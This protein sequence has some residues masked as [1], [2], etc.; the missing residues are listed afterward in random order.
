MKKYK[1]LIG[2]ESREAVDRYISSFE[3]DRALA[4]YIA[5]VLIAH[6]KQLARLG[7][8]KKDTAKTLVRELTDIMNSDGE[9]V[10]EWARTTGELYED[11]FEAIELYLYNVV[12]SDA[13]RIA[14]GRSRNDHI[15]AVLRL[16]IRDR[17]LEIAT[18]ILDLRRVLLDKASMYSGTLFPFFTHAQIA[19]CGSASI[20]FLT[21]EQAFADVFS[22][23]MLG[24]H[25]LNQ[26]PLGSGAAAGTFVEFD[27][28]SASREL[29]LSSD[30]LP[31]YYATGSRI[32]ILYMAS[33]LSIAMTEVGRFAE[34]MMLLTNVVGQGIAVPKHHISTSSIMPPQ[35]KTL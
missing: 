23:L 27:R 29:C 13:G 22:M 24:L 18:K 34:D 2:A 21:Y 17:V 15:A 10:Y 1:K 8:V 26:N 9:K 16:A 32:F 20:F 12:G 30:L 3:F 7:Y 14:L 5:M 35:E 11:F 6:V 25:F 31:P 33:V 19:Q 28:N 4:K